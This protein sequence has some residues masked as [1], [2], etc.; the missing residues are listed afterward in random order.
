MKL[1][2]LDSPIGRAIALVADLVILNLLFLFSCVPVVTV[3]AACG[4]LYD[5]VN[6]MLAGDCAAVSRQYFG[7]FKKCFKRGSVL[8]LLSVAVIGVVAFDALCALQLQNLMGAL[9][10]GVILAS[11]LF[12]L[13]VMAL[14]PMAVCRD[15]EAKLPEL[16]KG[17]FLLAMKGTWRTALAVV[18]NALP[19]V[20]LLFS[21]LL[22]IQTWM[23]WFL[24]GFA[25]L[26]YVNN[27]LLLKPV[28][29][30]AWDRIKP[31]KKDQK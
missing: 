24:V 30:E 1:F 6:A 25:A 27:W 10:L 29:P 15:P 12:V 13:A 26:A 28:D 17:S 8:F 21:P 18:L 22:F 23:F 5:T 2:S 3:G 31:V 4:A 19:F 20:L 9:S 7:A 11:L 16:V 14:L